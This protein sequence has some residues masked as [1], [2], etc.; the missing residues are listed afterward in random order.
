MLTTDAGEAEFDL[1]ADVDANAVR[2]R[3][4]SHEACVVRLVAAADSSFREA[5]L[6]LDSI[7]RSVELL[8]PRQGPRLVTSRSLPNVVQCQAPL[9]VAGSDGRDDT[10]FGAAGFVRRR[11]WRDLS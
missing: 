1:G 11:L 7:E 4:P 3:V 10:S 8:D 5:F 9:G 6:L 2:M